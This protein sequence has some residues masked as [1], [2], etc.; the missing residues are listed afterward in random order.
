M[1][2]RCPSFHFL[3]FETANKHFHCKTITH[4]IHV[5]LY[6]QHYIKTVHFWL[7]YNGFA[8]VR[9]KTKLIEG[10]HRGFQDYSHTSTFF[11]FF[12]FFWKS[13][14][15]WLCTFFCRAS[16]VFSNYGL[17]CIFIQASFSINFLSRPIS[18]NIDTL[19]RCYFQEIPSIFLQHHISKDSIVFLYDFFNVHL[20]TSYWNTAQTIY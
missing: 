13:K 12:T 19:V 9:K 4:I 3:H 17:Y 6:I 20:S 16:Y 5:M 7:K 1:R 2:K 18:S 11:T 14:K 8:T 10:G 15:L